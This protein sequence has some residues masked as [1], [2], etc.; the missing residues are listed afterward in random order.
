L[1]VCLRI[2]KRCCEAQIACAVDLQVKFAKF[3]GFYTPTLHKVTSLCGKNSLFL[4]D[5][6]I[7]RGLFV[8]SIDFQTLVSLKV[9]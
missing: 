8:E 7:G 3:S 4:T 9:N 5:K 2:A 1:L 6:A